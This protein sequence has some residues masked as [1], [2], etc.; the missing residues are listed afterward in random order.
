M[1][2]ANSLPQSAPVPSPC[3][4]ICH[5]DAQGLCVGCRRL[6]AEIAEWPYASAARQREILLLLALRPPR[7]DITS[8]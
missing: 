3:V 1:T 6:G 2:A 7:A 5:L 8:S 4:G